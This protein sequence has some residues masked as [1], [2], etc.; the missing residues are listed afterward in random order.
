[1]LL[2]R[3]FYALLYPQHHLALHHEVRDLYVKYVDQAPQRAGVNIEFKTE[4]QPRRTLVDRIEDVSPAEDRTP[5]LRIW[6]VQH[7][8]PLRHQRSYR[9][10]RAGG[11][12]ERED[13]PFLE[14]LKLRDDPVN[15]VYAQALGSP[16]S[17]RNRDHPCRHP[18]APSTAR[19]L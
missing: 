2:L 15:A 13:V 8:P 12:I 6:K 17:R 14:V 4:Y 3:L 1:M 18:S 10:P 19:S 7:N 5:G 16:A 9:R 11:R